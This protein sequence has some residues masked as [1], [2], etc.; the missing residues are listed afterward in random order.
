MAGLNIGFKLWYIYIKPRMKKEDN[1]KICKICQ[2]EFVPDKFHPNQ[3]VC[4]NPL[5]QHKRE[6]LN[7][8]KW[9]EANPDYFKYKEKKSLWEQKRAKYLELWRKTHKNYFKLIRQKKRANKS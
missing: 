1:I 4:L 5:C 9:R 7:Q 6:L 8:K 2:K 3:Q